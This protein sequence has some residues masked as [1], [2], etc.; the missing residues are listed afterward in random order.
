MN[1]IACVVFGLVLAL[2]LTSILLPDAEI[3]WM[4]EHWSWFNQ[5][6][7]VIERIGGALNLVHTVLFVLP[8]MATRVVMPGVRLKQVAAALLLFGISS[9][10]VQLLVPGRHPPLSDVAVDLMPGVLGWAAMRGLA[11]RP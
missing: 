5:P 8:G 9:E 3:A 1:P 2:V 11:A 6:M 4:R 10:L 7:L